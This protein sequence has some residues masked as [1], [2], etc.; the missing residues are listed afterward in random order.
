MSNNSTRAIAV[1]GD[2]ID[3]KRIKDRF[4][5]QQ[6]L[7]KRLKH[8]GAKRTVSPYTL[9]LGDEFQALYVGADGLFYDLFHLREYLYPVR[10]RFSIALGD[11][12]TPINRKQAIGMDGSAFHEARWQID[13]MKKGGH[14]LGIAGLPKEQGDLLDPAVKILW[15]ST[16]SWNPNRMKVLRMNYDQNRSSPKD[17]GLKISDRAINKNTREGQLDDWAQLMRATEERLDTFLAMET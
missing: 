7:A 2:L 3:S 16:S 12:T 9:T 14:Q 5:F 10:C 11:I 1:I 4:S 17:Y 6:Q 8:I 15:A 13:K